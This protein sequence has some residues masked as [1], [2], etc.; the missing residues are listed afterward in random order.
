MNEITAICYKISV[1][2]SEERRIFQ[3][4]RSTRKISEC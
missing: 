2:K 4:F 3:K 1:G